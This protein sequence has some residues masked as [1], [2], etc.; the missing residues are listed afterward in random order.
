MPK[1]KPKTRT[2]VKDPP[3]RNPGQSIQEQITQV[4]DDDVFDNFVFIF[5]AFAVFLFSVLQW[6][7][8]IPR[9]VMAAVTGLVF[10]G[11]IAYSLP[12]ILRARDKIIQLRL[13]HRGELTVA[14]SLDAL[15]DEGFKIVH[16]V[17]ADGFNI[18]HVAIGPKGIFTI[19]TKTRSKPVDGNP[20]IHYDGERIRIGTFEPD[21]NPLDQAEAQASWLARMLEESTGKRFA[22]RPVIAY[23]GWYVEGPGRSRGARVWVLEPKAL[24]G[25]LR[26]EP[27]RMKQEDITLA[28]YH[29]KR[30]IKAQ[31]E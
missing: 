31:A 9:G 19:E 1:T 30:Y 16:D 12:K 4:R 26:Y 21:R 8:P 10:V 6:L 25:Y 3:I 24:R 7:S 11:A 13:G 27:I 17:V 18:D 5:V 28:T 20:R 23:P 22:V 2:P 29:L 15:R 14:E